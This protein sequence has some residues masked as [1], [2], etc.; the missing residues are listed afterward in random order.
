[1]NAHAKAA[2]APLYP[3]PMHFQASVVLQHALA[4]IEAEFIRRRSSLLNE[5]AD[6]ADAIRADYAA[7][8]DAE[9]VA[10]YGATA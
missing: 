1:M 2:I 4:D 6:K 5:A 7:L 3:A 10:K 9:F 8:P